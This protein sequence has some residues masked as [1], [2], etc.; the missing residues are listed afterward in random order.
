VV[1]RIDVHPA[2]ETRPTRHIRFPCQ[3]TYVWHT[4]L[5]GGRRTWWSFTRRWQIWTDPTAPKKKG[6]WHNPQHA[7]WPIRESIP[8]FSLE[9]ANEAGGVSQA[10]VGNQLLGLP[11]PYHRHAIGTFNTCSLGPTHRSLNDTGGGYHREG[12]GLPH[13]TPH[14]SQPA[15]SPFP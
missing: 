12:A 14:P 7:D 13:T 10:P 4:L 1:I 3:S 15:I 8:G 11:G 5:V 6:S 2:G 9:P